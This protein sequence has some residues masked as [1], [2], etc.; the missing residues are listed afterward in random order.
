MDLRGFRNELGGYDMYRYMGKVEKIVGMSIESSGP[1]C[2]IGD[3]C[4]IYSKDMQKFIYA[5][6]VGFQSEKVLLM[7]YTDIEG[8][9]PGSIVDNTG[10]KLRV[11]TGQAMI[12]RIINAIGE[13]I[14][15]KGEI[16]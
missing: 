11:K 1:E 6:V 3:I 13:P 10:D 12:G 14:D 9:G 2:N 15:G 4:R 16:N 5:E 8:V 7:P